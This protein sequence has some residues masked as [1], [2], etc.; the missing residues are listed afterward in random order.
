MRARSVLL[1]LAG[2][3]I[4]AVGGHAYP[5][6]RDDFE[7]VLEFGQT[8]IEH[9][10]VIPA[11][12]PDGPGRE[13]HA[14]LHEG[15]AAASCWMELSHFERL[16]PEMAAITDQDAS[17]RIIVSA[18]EVLENPLASFK[19]AVQ[20]AAALAFGPPLILVLGFVLWRFRRK[21][22]GQERE[23]LLRPAPL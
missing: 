15:S 13:S 6:L 17:A 1:A 7:Q 14:I 16:Y 5:A 20:R 19:D 18:D 21:L 8:A 9:P 4:I 23:P 2:S 12:C 3:W 22:T 10:P 11:Q